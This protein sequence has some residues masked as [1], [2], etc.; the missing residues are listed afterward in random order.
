MEFKYK[1]EMQKNGLTINDLP[2]D[3]QTG[4]EQLNDVAK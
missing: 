2:E 3:A 1:E 4:I